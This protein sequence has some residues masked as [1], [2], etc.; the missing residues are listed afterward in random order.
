VHYLKIQELFFIKMKAN[1]K[2]AEKRQT[3]IRI[4]SLV[5]VSGSNI[6]SSS[7]V[8]IIVNYSNPYSRIGIILASRKPRGK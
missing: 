1:P 7:V 8:M 6:C 5:V 2:K 3:Y 4:T